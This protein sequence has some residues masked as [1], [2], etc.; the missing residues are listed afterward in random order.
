VNIFQALVLGIVQGATEFLPVSSSA[1]LILVPWL[2][3]WQ[4]PGLGF[5]VMLHWGTLVAVLVYFQH[6]WRLLI[7]GFWH[8]LFRSTRDLQNNFYQRMAWLLVIASV[9][10]AVVGKVFEEQA[11]NTF[12]NPILIAAT[13]GGF[14]LILLIA[15]RWGARQKKLDG[16]RWWEALLI[17]F[18]QALAII[19]G[20]SRS[21]STIA[22]GLGLGFRREEAARFSFL[23]SMPIIFGAGL[24]KIRY[25]N[26]DADLA[27]LAVGF[28]SSAVFG[29][30]SIRY[31]LRYVSK[32]DFKIF[33]WYRIALAVVILIVFL[34][35][36]R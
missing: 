27:A 21:G 7:R 16:I 35:R 10:G 25:L 12:R 17:G 34:M 4:D 8:Y 32:H 3:G 28:L 18:S 26:G 23:M 14:G 22:A 5:D 20:V 19:P 13:V 36:V 31:L 33:V 1:H 15:D 6:D 24:V 30:L 29:F 2:F 11:E 9:P